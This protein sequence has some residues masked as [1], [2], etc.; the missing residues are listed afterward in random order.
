MAKASKEEKA[1]TAEQIL[2]SI[3]D[4]HKDEHLNDLPDTFYKVSSGSLNLDYALNGGF[5][6]GIHRF[7]GVT[8]GGKT[9]EALE[10][11]R[12]FFKQFAGASKGLFI[13]A[14]GR[15]SPELRKRSGMTFVSKVEDWKD[16]TIFVLESNI[17]EVAAKA[18]CK[19]CT[20]MRDIKLC[21]ILDS[22][23]G[24]ITRG[25]KEK[26]FGEATKVAGGAVVAGLLMKHLGAY[27]SKLGHMLIIIS[28]VRAKVETGYSSEPSRQV[29]ATG[30][31][32]LQHSADVMIEFWTQTNSDQILEKDGE[33]PDIHKNRILGHYANAR[34]KK[35]TN[36]S[37]RY[38]IKYPIRHGVIGGSIWIEREI[39]EMLMNFSYI[40]KSGSWLSVT[41]DLVTE[42]NEFAGKK[43]FDG[44]EKAQ[45]ADNMENV[46]CRDKETTEILRRFIL[47]HVI[48]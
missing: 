38:N 26:D 2:S 45:G 46:I 30:G 40:K 42:V 36:E 23:D 47:E 3:M 9:S 27:V 8:E 43:I 5:G 4:A 34:I 28:Q 20:E 17:Y 21:I 22:V 31:N 48:A 18:I 1:V 16:G 10:V 39:M 7:M 13:K 12:N 19:L 41:S 14:E 35:S 11:M 44:T 33:Q 25:D 6:P 29:S 37:T 32:A 15:L 24:L